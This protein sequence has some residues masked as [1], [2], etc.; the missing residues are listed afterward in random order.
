MAPLADP[1]RTR[2]ANRLM[3]SGNNVLPAVTPVHD[4]RP[5]VSSLFAF[6]GHNPA[7]RDPA[8]ER[9]V[10]DDDGCGKLPRKR[11]TN[12]SLPD[13]APGRKTAPIW[14]AVYK[15]CEN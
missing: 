12:K 14:Q 15:L 6:D 9:R 11:S 2:A 1:I 7:I 10:A 5:A 3:G 8:E 13:R 4:A